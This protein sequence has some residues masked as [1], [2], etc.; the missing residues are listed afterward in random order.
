[1]QLAQTWPNCWQLTLCEMS[2]GFV[3]LY[4][5]IWQRPVSMNISR[6]SDILGKVIRKRGMFTNSQLNTDPLCSLA[7][8]RTENTTSN[9][10]S[11][12][13]CI[14]CFATVVVCCIF[15]QPLPRNGCF[16]GSLI[17]AVRPH[18]AISNANTGIIFVS[19]ITG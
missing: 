9:I 2:L 1:V 14:R 15:T 17:L 7:A 3:C 19:T 10:S 8:D 16:C 11:I 5:A 18:V 6:D 12:V 13:A 4:P